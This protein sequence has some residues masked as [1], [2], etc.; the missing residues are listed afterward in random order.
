MN[1]YADSVERD[2]AIKLR[3]RSLYRDASDLWHILMNEGG[4]SYRPGGSA[5]LP[6]YGYMVADGEHEMKVRTC[7]VETIY[8][9]IQENLDTLSDSRYIGAWMDEDYVYLDVSEWFRHGS[10]ARHTGTQR[11]QK[12]IWDIANSRSVLL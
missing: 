7:T 8:R 10:V 11:N 4:F 5:R 9:Y 1:A 6:N 3:D 12:A 2:A